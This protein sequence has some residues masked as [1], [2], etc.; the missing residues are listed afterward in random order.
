LGFHSNDARAAVSTGEPLARARG[1]E[2][3]VR[4][5]KLR[6]VQTTVALWTLALDSELVFVGDA[7]TTEASAPSRRYGIEFANYG[8][9]NRWTTFDVDLSFSNAEFTGEN[10]GEKVPGAVNRVVQA[11]LTFE[12]TRPLFGS[13]RLRHFG[14]RPLI[15]DA[16]VM[17]RSTTIVNA[18][19]GYALS[20]R[21]RLVMEVFNLGN[22]K[23]SD[24]DYFYPSRLPGEPLE[25]VDDVHTHPTPPR[26]ARIA[27][28]VS[29]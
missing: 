13:I 3:G 24:I 7:G 27:L 17:S 1:A 9:I 23:V 25:G 20:S 14:P 16:S 29:F 4:T 11:G 10:A 8:R 15:E 19:V 2:V 21:A 28:H 5:V 6:G 12:P 18:E 26:T 22:A